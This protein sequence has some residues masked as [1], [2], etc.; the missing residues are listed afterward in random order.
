MTTEIYQWATLSLLGLI[1]FTLVVLVAKTIALIYEVMGVNQRIN[2]L[3]L[4][5]DQDDAQSLHLCGQVIEIKSILKERWGL[6]PEE[7]EAEIQAWGEHCDQP[8]DIEA[9]AKYQKPDRGVW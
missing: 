8:N 4:L 3:Y 6:R 9:D 7:S 5:H 1:F 2:A